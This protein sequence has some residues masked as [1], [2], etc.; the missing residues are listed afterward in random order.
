MANKHRN[1]LGCPLAATTVALPLTGVPLAMRLSFDGVCSVLPAD[2]AGL[3]DQI[4]ELTR[5]P[6]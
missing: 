1:G 3:L 4:D 5:L 6:E 2:F